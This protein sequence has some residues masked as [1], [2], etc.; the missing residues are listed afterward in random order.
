[1]KKTHQYPVRL[2][3][4]TWLLCSSIAVA[5][6]FDLGKANELL[7]AGKS[8]EGYALLAPHEY[9]MAGNVDYDYLLGIAALDSGHPDKASL[10]LE[11][12]L[13][14]NPRHYGARLDLARAYFALADFERARTEFSRVMEQNPP[15]LAK[16]TIEKYLA[17]ID[18]KLNPKPSFTGY[19]EA[20][21]GY[22]TNVNA[23]TS[24]S[25]MYIPIFGATFSLASS[26]LA[27]R[28]NYLTLGGGGEA[29]FPLRQ[30]LSLFVGVDGKK[31]TNF[32]KDIYNT[33]S[34]D[35]KVGLNI[36]N[37][38]SVFRLSLQKGAFYLDDKYNRDT[39][40]LSGEWRLVPDPRN[41]YSLFGQYAELRYGH[42]KTGADLSANDVDQTILGGGWL[43]ALDEGGKVV[44][45]GS[46]Y[47]GSERT[48]AQFP[49]ID[50]DQNFIGFRAGGQ[51]RLNDH[52]SLF[53]TLGY[54]EG[55]YNRR[56][57]LFLDYRRDTQYDLNVGVNWMPAQNW[58]IR[59]QFTYTRNDSNIAINDYDRKDLS[60]TVRRDF[61]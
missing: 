58:T 56:N 50:G 47:A 22:D 6:E 14:V 20:T 17:A 45:F 34:F 40:G 38:N 18:D 61:K 46:V 60:M 30:E 24:S 9:E 49:R 2:T 12:V 51:T 29:V 32:F 1:M 39:Q 28:D 48:H 52:S 54:K 8:K 4:L 7:K 37:G 5:A 31:R 53:A 33:D 27:E 19:L 25:T 41:Q 57:L 10:A 26:N 16:A 35:G 15:P 44:L 3:A 42:D 21:L 55:T 43:H 59:P 36:G 11:R 23:A 13:A